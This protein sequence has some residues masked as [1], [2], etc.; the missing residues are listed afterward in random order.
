[1]TLEERYELSCYEEVSRLH[2]LKDIWLVR[3]NEDGT[4]YVKKRLELYNKV[5]YERLMEGKFANIPE[6]IMC[7]EEDDKLVVIEEYIHGASLERILEKDGILSEQRVLQIMLSLCDILDNLH[8]SSPPII[9]R[10]IKPSNIMISSDGVVKLIDFNAAKE[11]SYG[12]EEDT[13]LMGTKKFAAPEQYGFGQSDPRTDIYALGITM[14]YL[15]T[16]TYPGENELS[17]IF[18]NIIKKCIA[19]DKNERYQ[20]VSSLKVDLQKLGQ[21]ASHG[22]LRDRQENDRKENFQRKDEDRKNKNY[23]TMPLYARKSV[24]P[25][26]FRSGIVWKMI[27]A[28]YGYALIFWMC[29]NTDVVGSDGV[30]LKGYPLWANRIAILIIFLGGIYFFGNYCDIRYQLPLMK[31]NRILHW[32]LAFV[33]FL[34]FCLLVIILLALAGGSG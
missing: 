4:F 12:H 31:K 10:D 34:L 25:I 14:H 29:W 26:G 30:A 11:F 1:M 5:V 21:G 20:T 13:R 6:I 2:E 17:G 15:L 3:H 28:V 19:L 33:Y 32:L 22:Y 9:H 16:M 7:V 27:V 18:G 24:F 23:F 8:R